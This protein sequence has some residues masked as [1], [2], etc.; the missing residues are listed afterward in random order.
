MLYYVTNIKPAVLHFEKNP[1]GSGG[2]MYEFFAT[3]DGRWALGEDCIKEIDDRYSKET[4]SGMKPVSLLDSMNAD[5][6]V[7]SF[8]KMIVEKDIKLKEYGTI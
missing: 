6:A 1:D 4:V 7:T 2:R 8:S 3:D 5:E